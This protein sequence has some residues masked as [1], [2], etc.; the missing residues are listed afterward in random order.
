[1]YVLFVYV[2]FFLCYTIFWNFDLK[3]IKIYFQPVC[4]FISFDFS[5]TWC[6]MSAFCLVIAM[7]LIYLMDQELL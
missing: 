2:L 6:I 5:I 3:E 7:L 1:M 4:F